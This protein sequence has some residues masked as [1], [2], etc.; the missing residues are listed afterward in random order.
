MIQVPC[1]VCGVPV[2][3]GDAVQVTCIGFDENGEA[4]TSIVHQHCLYT[5]DRRN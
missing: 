4:L 2:V 1:E 5:H 3:A